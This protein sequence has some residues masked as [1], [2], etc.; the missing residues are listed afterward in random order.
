MD[1]EL[2]KYAE[3]YAELGV[4]DVMPK[5]AVI[6]QDCRER[7]VLDAV[8][9]MSGKVAVSL[10]DFY[11][12]DV[13]KKYNGEGD[14]SERL[15]DAMC[16]QPDEYEADS[17]YSIANPLL[18]TEEANILWGL[19]CYWGEIEGEGEELLEQ[20][21][22]DMEQVRSSFRVNRVFEKFRNFLVRASEN[23]G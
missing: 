13:L 5:W 18:L 15:Y 11:Y 1:I 19:E 7:E 20:L 6:S 22:V 9:D 12:P 3:V 4:E 16:V 23:A 14:D 2:E 21:G 8:G 10:G 17:E